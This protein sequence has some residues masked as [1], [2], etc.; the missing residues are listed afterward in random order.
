MRRDGPPPDGVF[1]S[2]DNVPPHQS[3][4]AGHHNARGP[5][6]SIWAKPSVIAL[7]ETNRGILIP[8]KAQPG[9]RRNA[10]LGEHAGSLK[11]A[12]TQ[13]P[14][15]GKANSAIASLLAEQLGLKPGQVEL[16]AGATSSHKKFLVCGIARE[17]L[18]QRIERSMAD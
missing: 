5:P 3:G 8:V 4:A 6:P 18:Q 17:E 14:E 12:V 11:V 16:S 2:S 15:K 9:A 1:P 7:V 13:A 10:I